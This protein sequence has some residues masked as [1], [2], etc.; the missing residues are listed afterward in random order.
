MKKNFALE[1]QEGFISLVAE[2]DNSVAERRAPLGKKFIDFK[3]IKKGCNIIH[4][5]CSGFPEDSK[6]N[7]SNIYCLDDS[8]QIK[9]SIEVPLDNNCFPNPIQWHRKMEKKNDSKGNLNLTY[10]TN[11]ETFTC[12]DWRGVTVS[13]E[14]ETGKTIESELTK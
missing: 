7:A 2:D 14:Y 12:A 3:R 11:T 10:V 9:W 4:E 6:G 8:F 13:V 1:L 5:D